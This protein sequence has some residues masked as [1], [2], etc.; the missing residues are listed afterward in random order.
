MSNFPKL[1]RLKNRTL[2]TL[3]K[4]LPKIPKK[5]VQKYHAL[6]ASISFPTSNELAKLGEIYAFL[7]EYNKFIATFAVCTPKCS[8]CCHIPVQI[9]PIEAEFIEIQT[10]VKK[11]FRNQS[12][13][14]NSPCPFLDTKGLCS[15]YESRPFN[16]RTFHAIENPHYCKTGEPQL[17]YGNA[18]SNYGSNIL[19]NLRDKVHYMNHSIYPS[20]IVGDIRHFFDFH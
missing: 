1:A 14:L 12:V 20:L 9:T 13:N 4:K 6:L 18:G 2:V 19:L 5:L 8:Y 10:G 16:C 3:F 7:D 17:T 11:H 15:V